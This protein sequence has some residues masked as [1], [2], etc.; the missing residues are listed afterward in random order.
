MSYHDHEKECISCEGHDFRQKI[1]SE[2]KRNQKSAQRYKYQDP[3]L[4]IPPVVIDMKKKQC[5]LHHCDNFPMLLRLYRVSQGVPGCPRVSQGVP[6]CTIEYV[7]HNITTQTLNLWNFSQDFWFAF[8]R[9]Q[10]GRKLQKFLNR[11]N[12]EL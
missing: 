7:K 12:C 5:R 6:G 2:V 9:H 10:T 1:M 8:I 4:H 11:V 3:L